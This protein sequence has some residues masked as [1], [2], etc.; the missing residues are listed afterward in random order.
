M[1]P[2]RIWFDPPHLRWGRVLATVLIASALLGLWVAQRRGLFDEPQARAVV[3][4]GAAAAS[5]PRRAEGG[6][7]P[8]SAPIAAVAPAKAASSVELICG[9]GAVNFDPGDEKRAEQAAHEAFDK[10]QAHRERVMPGW[11]EEMKSSSDEQ[12]QAG[13]WFLEARE[14]LAKQPE[15]TNKA[16]AL[17]SL[18]ELARLAERSRD[19]LPYAL[20][21]QTCELFQ[22]VATAPACSALRVEAWAERDPGNAFPWLVAASRQGVTAQRRSQYIENAIAAGEMRG[23]WGALHG[24]LAKAAP[25][26]E[27]PLDRSV[28]FFEAMAADS[29]VAVPQS[30]VV[31]HCSDN[32]LRQGARRQQCER[33]AAFLT[34]KG[35]SYLF[36]SVGAGIGRRLGWSED[37]LAR[38]KAEQEA[39][40][41]ALPP[42]ILGAGCD[43]L[44]RAEAYFA[45]VAKY[46]E[47]GALRR[48]QQ[49]ER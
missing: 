44:A 32:A 45:D 27:A 13:A 26:N 28:R 36:A 42:D 48:R 41:G 29:V 7:A 23:T 19:P 9:L 31:D 11:L 37:R 10:L 47:L 15:A 2:R 22:R 30:I 18:D 12:V 40:I 33:L 14:A 21:F 6:R 34:D 49:A 5:A 20:A 1:D 16:E 43:G 39:F 3:A 35:D 24:V 4:V 17:D 38:L 8:E 46:G 25:A